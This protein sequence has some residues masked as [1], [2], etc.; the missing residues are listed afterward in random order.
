M[1]CFSDE[2]LRRGVQAVI[3]LHDRCDVCGG[4]NDDAHQ[5]RPHVFEGVD[6]LQL[7]LDAARHQGVVAPA[8]R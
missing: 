2:E 1:R 3:A 4:L 8:R 5:Q 6:P 7:F